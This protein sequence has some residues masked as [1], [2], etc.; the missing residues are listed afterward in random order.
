MVGEKKEEKKID[1]WQ[2]VII[3]DV[4]KDESEWVTFECINEQEEATTLLSR[5]ENANAEGLDTG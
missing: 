5:P 4:I 2:E 1:H 3:S